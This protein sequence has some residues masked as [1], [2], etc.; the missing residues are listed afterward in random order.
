MARKSSTSRAS[1]FV[2][3]GEGVSIYPST[4]ANLARAE[5]QRK[6]ELARTQKA[7]KKSP[8]R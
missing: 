4:P 7:A 5:A 1:R 3:T 6:A 2:T 8:K